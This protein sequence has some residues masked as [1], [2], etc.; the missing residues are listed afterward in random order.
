MLFLQ[1]HFS[2]YIRTFLMSLTSAFAFCDFYNKLSKLMPLWFILLL[3]CFF[4]TV[5][6]TSWQ[7][8]L[9]FFYDMWV[10]RVSL[11][12]LIITYLSILFFLYTPYLQILLLLLW[13]LGYWLPVETFEVTEYEVSQLVF[14]LSL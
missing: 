4:V 10:C 14:P 13:M 6:S 2:T 1:C 7:L 11:V 8:L 9:G 12:I 5:N 3:F